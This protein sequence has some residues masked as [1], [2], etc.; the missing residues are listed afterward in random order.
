M[1]KDGTGQVKKTIAYTNR[2]NPL[3]LRCPK[4][5][6]ELVWSGAI[7]WGIGQE[8]KINPAFGLLQRR[9]FS[10]LYVPIRLRVFGRRRIGRRGRATQKVG[11]SNFNGD[12]LG[13][14][15][16]RSQCSTQR[17]AVPF[18]LGANINNGFCFRN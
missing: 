13:R 11:P 3:C 5:K 18:P 1:V 7:L 15:L 8:K 14:R 17:A 2:R 10:G 16:E 4:E 12:I 6:G 9:Q